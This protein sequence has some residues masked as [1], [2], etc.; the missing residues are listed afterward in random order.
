MEDFAKSMISLPWAA[1][2]FGVRQATTLLHLQSSEQPMQEV[3]DGFNK[4]T[5]TV[6]HQ[7]RGMFESTF[8]TGDRL[9][10]QMTD[11]MFNIMTLNFRR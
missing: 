11:M 6:E 9:Q 4:S 5:E 8:K 2:L 1:C 3:A 10:Q 7:L